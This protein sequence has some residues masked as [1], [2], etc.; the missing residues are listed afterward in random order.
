MT[1]SACEASARR[2]RSQRSC[3]AALAEPALA[4]ADASAHHLQH[5]Q[6]FAG[7]DTF[8]GKDRERSVF[9]GQGGVTGLSFSSGRFEHN[10]VNAISKDIF[11]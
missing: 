11:S 6:A 7:I 4:G 2:H 9:S 8:L 10:L 5:M 3:F 1:C